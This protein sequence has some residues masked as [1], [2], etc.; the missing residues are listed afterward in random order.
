MRKTWELVKTA[1]I[2]VHMCTWLYIGFYTF[3]KRYTV[4]GIK[5]NF[6]PSIPKHLEMKIFAISSIWKGYWDSSWEPQGKKKC[7]F[8][9]L[10]WTC[11]G[12]FMR[13]KYQFTQGPWWFFNIPGSETRMLECLFLASHEMLKVLGTRVVLWIGFSTKDK[14]ISAIFLQD[15]S[16]D[17]S[18]FMDPLLESRS[19]TN[20]FN[21]AA[22]GLMTV[23]S[24]PFLLN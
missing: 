17:W 24:Y 4:E 18:Q 3:W 10:R 23:T 15:T 2:S 5:A 12:I 20:T 16:R 1:N 14:H 21:N 22:P 7:H 8:F 11:K 9:L 19:W 6:L 13:W